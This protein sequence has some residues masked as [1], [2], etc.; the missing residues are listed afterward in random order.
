MY[1]D[2]VRGREFM[3][4]VKVYPLRCFR[5]KWEAAKRFPFSGYIRKHRGCWIISDSKEDYIFFAN[6]INERKRK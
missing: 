3:E 4:G 6:R 5:S 2:R 1:R